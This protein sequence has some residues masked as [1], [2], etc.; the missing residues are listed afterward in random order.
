M[1]NNNII[2]YDNNACVRRTS[3]SHLNVVYRPQDIK[4]NYHGFLYYL[5][6]KTSSLEVHENYFILSSL[7]PDTEFTFQVNKKIPQFVLIHRMSTNCVV[8]TGWVPQ[9]N[10]LSIFLLYI[11]LKG[12]CS[13]KKGMRRSSH[14]NNSY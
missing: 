12:V 1:M 9:A 10:N 14:S 13:D 3:I 6:G 11:C 4:S 8:P 5:L 2:F 7:P